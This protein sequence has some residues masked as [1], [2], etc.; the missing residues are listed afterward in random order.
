MSEESSTD[1]MLILQ[2]DD[3][4]VDSTQL[5][6]GGGLLLSSTDSDEEDSMAQSP[7][8][9]RVSTDAELKAR[10][11]TKDK[12]VEESAALET[13][14]IGDSDKDEERNGNGKEEDAEQLEEMV[15]GEGEGLEVTNNQAQI[16]LS[17]SASLPASMCYPDMISCRS[18]DKC[19]GKNDCGATVFCPWCS[20]FSL[21]LASW[22][23]VSGQQ[24]GSNLVQFFDLPFVGYLQ[25][26]ALTERLNRIDEGAYGVVY[27]AKDKE[28]GEIVALKRIKMDKFTEGA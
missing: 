27:R 16:P 26:L 3:G 17:P 23:L 6:V 21:V 8:R 24:V 13:Q 20:V 19:Y 22:L 9:Q 18:V 2:N 28:T 11:S 15:D 5:R 7:K 14:R 10:E 25:L 1:S 4:E 12:T